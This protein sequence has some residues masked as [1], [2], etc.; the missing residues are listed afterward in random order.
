M[1]TTGRLRKTF[2]LLTPAAQAQ[3]RGKGWGGGTTPQCGFLF[4]FNSECHYGFELEHP[5]TGQ[6]S[7]AWLSQAVS[8]ACWGKDS[9]SPHRYRVSGQGIPRLRLMEGR[10][11]VSCPSQD[12]AGAHGRAAGVGALIVGG[13]APPH[14]AR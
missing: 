5:R 4:R 1:K 7:L 12:P 9:L 13:L 2:R 6:A 8:L 3:P 11:S 14:S 10:R